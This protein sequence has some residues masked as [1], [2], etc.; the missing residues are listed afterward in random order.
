M[1]MKSGKTGYFI[2]KNEQRQHF[3]DLKYR[4]KNS[5]FLLLKLV[6]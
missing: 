5:T 3:N 1:C 2:A 6:F 4:K